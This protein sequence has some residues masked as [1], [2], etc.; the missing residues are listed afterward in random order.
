[1]ASS[2]IENKENERKNSKLISEIY[3]KEYAE[4]NF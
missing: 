1:M 2:T 4:R 3:A